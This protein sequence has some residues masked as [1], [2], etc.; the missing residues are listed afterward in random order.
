MEDPVT[1]MTCDGAEFKVE[2]QNAKKSKTVYDLV[3]DSGTEIPIP[4]SGVQSDVMKHIVTY[5][6]N[7]KIPEVDN[8]MLFNIILAS[9]YMDIPELLDEMCQRVADMIKGKTPDEI[10]KIF[11]VENDFTEEEEEKI[12]KQNEW[13][14]G[15]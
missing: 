4:L 8:T 9:N 12:K 1:F 15:A 5:L 11:N 14:E 10:R 13:H 7:E 6:N 3:E 2:Y